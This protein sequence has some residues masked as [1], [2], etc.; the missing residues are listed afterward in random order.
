MATTVFDPTLGGGEGGWAGFTI[1]EVVAAANLLAATGN[2][3]RVTLAFTTLANGTTIQAYIGQQA[4]AGDAYD[5]DSAVQLT[6]SGSGTI[7]G[8]GSTL[9][10]VSDFVTLPQSYDNTKNYIVCLQAS[11]GTLSTWNSASGT[12]N[13]VYYKSG[14]D[15]ATINKSGYSSDGAGSRTVD[16]IE[17]QAGAGGGSA[18]PLYMHRAQQMLN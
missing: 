2:Q 16:K 11:A 6:F 9:S 10:Y 13:A 12:G 3:A 17:I 4:A 14:A 15:A 18:V 7:T 5:F 1:V 8:N